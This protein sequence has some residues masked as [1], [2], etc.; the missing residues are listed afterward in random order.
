MI[1]VLILSYLINLHLSTNSFF[2]TQVYNLCHVEMETIY[3]FPF[4]VLYIFLGSP[5]SI[6]F[7]AFGGENW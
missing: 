6:K 5:W 7:Y 3:Y 2:P 1:M 4:L